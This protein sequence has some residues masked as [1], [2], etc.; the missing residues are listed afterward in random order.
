MTVSCWIYLGA[1]LLLLAYAGGVFDIVRG[2]FDLGR[3]T[4]RWTR[5]AA[6]PPRHLSRPELKAA[7]LQFGY[8][9]TRTV[10]ASMNGSWYDSRGR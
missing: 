4:S 3:K 1:L 8:F 9:P 10:P 7:L 5:P 2:I 6:A